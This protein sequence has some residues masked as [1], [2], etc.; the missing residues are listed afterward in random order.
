MYMNYRYSSFSRIEKR[1]TP[2]SLRALLHLQSQQVGFGT[3]H[4]LCLVA[5]LLVEG[6]TA[7]V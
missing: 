2:S 1:S 4:G 3:A 5:L 6:V 7:L